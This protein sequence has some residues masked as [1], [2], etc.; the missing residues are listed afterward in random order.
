M[1]SRRLLGAM[2][3]PILFVAFPGCSKEDDKPETRQLVGTAEKIN[4]ETGEVA[5]RF[6]HEK[7]GSEQIIEGSVTD[8]TEVLINGKVAELK[9]IR[10]KERV[11]VIGYRKGKGAGARI[12]AIR[13]EIE[14]PEWIETGGDA[15]PASADSAGDAGAEKADPDA[16][17]ETPGT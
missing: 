5:L 8:G 1:F 4:L 17:G 10:L 11:K 12:V 9:D 16:P 14:R 2:V 3:I 15:E 6:F 13:I 7:S